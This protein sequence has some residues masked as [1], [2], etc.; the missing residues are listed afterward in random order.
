[1]V[2]TTSAQASV[3]PGD[4]HNHFHA[5]WKWLRRRYLPGWWPTDGEVV[6]FDIGKVTVSRYR[7][8]GHQIATPWSRALGDNVA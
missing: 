8:R 2:A 6:L 7:Y 1:M 4:P 3:K 5:N